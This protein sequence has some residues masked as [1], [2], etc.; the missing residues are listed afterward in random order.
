[1]T[2]VI[3]CRPPR[4]P[5]DKLEAAARH[6]I[7]INPLNRPAGPDR[8]AVATT[9]YWGLD[10]VKLTVGFLDTTPGELRT[11]ILSHMNAWN[12]T[13]NVEFTETAHANDADIRINR[14]TLPDDDWNGYWS[15]L[16]TDIQVYAGPVNQNMNLE[17]FSLNTEEEEFY[18]V[19]RHEAGHALG[20]PH[21]HMRQEL[22]AKIDREKAIDYYHRM[23]G[24]DE[25]TIIAQVL[26]PLDP[27]SL[28][29]T[30]IADP[31][32]IMAY[33]VPAA[34]TVDGVAIPGGNDI[35][36]ADFNFIAQI[37]PK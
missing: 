12:Q 14:E 25:E 2:E 5:D 15:F 24:W 23:T 19:V 26:T 21:E 10:G 36:Q 11:K 9:K 17:G 8:L 3:T 28:N 27:N 32:S 1:M 34:I 31:N 30:P 6:A 29:A 13:A 4:I 18:R 20:F 35:S 37:Y 7:A 22:V 33:Q 16:G